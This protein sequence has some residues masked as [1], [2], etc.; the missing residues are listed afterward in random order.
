MRPAAYP[1]AA[2]VG[3]SEM[4]LALLLA[5]VD[6]RLGVLLRGE[7]GSGKTTAA[8]GLAPLLL[9][10]APFVN[11]PIGT[12]ED[13]LLG[14]LHLERTLKGDP[15]L[16]P[17]LLAE[18]HG[19]VLYID[20][21]N[22]LAPHL[23]D[24]ILDA[25]STGVHVVERE[26]LSA[27]H[28][29]E[30]VLLGSM[31]PEEGSLRPQL[32]DRFALSV[33]VHAPLDPSERRVVMERRISF[34]RDPVRFAAEWSAEQENLQ[35]KILSARASLS[36][37][38]CLP[39]VMDQISS[40]I[41]DHGVRSLR[42]DLAVLRAA[43]AYASLNG[44]TRVESSHVATVLPLVLAH[45]M[46]DGGPS[47]SR[48]PALQMPPPTSQANPSTKPPGPQASEPVHERVFAPS[49]VKAP[50]IDH[51]SK[52]ASSHSGGAATDSCGCGVI[53]GSRQSDL[54]VELDLRATLSHTLR[55]TGE[56]KT[57]AEDLHERVR[58]PRTGTHYLFVIDSSGSHAAQQRMR[59]VKGAISGL[60]GRSFKRGDEVSL[61]VFRGTSAQLILEPTQIL[62][63]ALATLEYL[64]TG[65]RTPLAAALQLAGT[66]LTDET[67]LILLTDGRANVALN[68]GDPWQEAV[69][70]ARQITCKA[71]VVDTEIAEQRLG[72]CSKL[73]DTLGARY[74]SLDELGE[75]DN[76]SIA[77]ERQRQGA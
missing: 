60:L 35:S 54:P 74:L 22:L 1:F 7:K 31:N 53:I 27:T 75:I 61:I 12:T 65:G 77:S 5:A 30:F 76:L 59:Q 69:D 14:G 25:A 28:A 13:R 56:W 62:P 50:V 45:R 24:S 2:L 4:K 71:I 11:L 34:E 52:A 41:C 36:S 17:G 19:G 38:S 51:G 8:R 40:T 66:Q 55:E 70:I 15:T 26:G 67:V 10:P 42:A 44:D 6:W 46:R 9:P 23:G 18:A 63:D 68:G 43:I 57:R 37:V 58:M 29:T 72:Q 49:D 21:V 47:S 64:P 39:E 3:Q 48:P 32:L 20:E 16:K 73:A 33:T